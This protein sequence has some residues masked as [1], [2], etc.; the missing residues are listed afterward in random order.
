MFEW[1]AGAYAVMMFTL[2]GS[3]GYIALWVSDNRRREDGYRVLRLLL[4][5]GTVSGIFW[6]LVRL[7]QMGAL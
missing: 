2:I 4:S 6:L 1:L 5:A 7:H 3:A